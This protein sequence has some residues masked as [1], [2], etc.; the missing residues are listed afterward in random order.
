MPTQP[1]TLVA[2]NIT[3]EQHE[4]VKA[5]AKAQGFR[6]VSDYLRHL[7]E[8]DAKAHGVVMPLKVRRVRPRGDDQGQGD[9]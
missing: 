4:Q 5:L 2:V 3:R 9:R 1:R 8:Q 6:Y 7:L